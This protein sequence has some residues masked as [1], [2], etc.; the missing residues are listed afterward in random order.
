MSTY[1]RLLDEATE[2]GL[3][4]IEKYPFASHRIRGLCYD[5]TIALSA[6]I[7]TEAERRV[8]LGE[9]LTH[10]TH[11]V[12]DILD[13]PR[14]ERRIRER[15]FDRLVGLS[16]LVNAYLAG[17]RDPWEFAEHLGVPEDFFAAL[18]Q[19]YKERFGT[20]ATVSTEQG[21]FTVSFEPIFRVRKPLRSS[22]KRRL[23]GKRKIRRY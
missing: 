20:R 5:D 22:Q 4:V 10:A 23:T 16:G 21:L 13:D 18:M 1:E 17:C 7:D 15:N 3:T 9:E 14:L 11:T 6:Q 8:I 2:K 12:G 19:N